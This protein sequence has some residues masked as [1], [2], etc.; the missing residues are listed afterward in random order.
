[1]KIFFRYNKKIISGGKNEEGTVTG[2][3]LK[4]TDLCVKNRRAFNPA[5]CRMSSLSDSTG[6]K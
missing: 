5:G 2:I 3:N 4:M 1:M 6:K